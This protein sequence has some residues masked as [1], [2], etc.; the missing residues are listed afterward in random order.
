MTL[1]KTLLARVSLPSGVFSTVWNNITFQ[2]FTKQ[3]NGGP[4]ECVIAYA[5]PFDYDGA[6]L[7]EGNDVELIVSDS[8]TAAISTAFDNG[9]FNTRT[10]YRGYISLIERLSDGSA[11][12]VTVHILGY[13]TLLALDVLKNGSQTTLYSK[14]TDGMTTVSGDL[15]AADIGLLFRAV[16][17]RFIAETGSTRIFYGPDDIPNTGTSATYIFQQKTYRDAIDK[18]KSLAPTNVYWYVDETGRISFKAVSS[19]PTHRFIIG[20][21]FTSVDVQRSLETVRNSVL[22]W[23]GDAIY[24]HYEDAASIALYGRRT[25]CLN[26]YGI[27]DTNAADAAGAKFLAENKDAAVTLT[28]TI[29]DNN[30]DAGLGYDIESIQPGD[31]CAFLGFSSNLSDIF[32]D[33]MII[34]EVAYNL[35]SVQI[36]VELVKS[37]LVDQQTSQAQD[38]NDI[39]TGGLGIAE[40]YS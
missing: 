20:R 24:K 17:D 11:E 27:S 30:N 21:H 34:T 4:G 14:S 3:L 7:R 13:Y 2:G 19:A 35:D 37:G 1:P 9:S 16:V 22:I 40:S 12:T 26:D 36:K 32:R 8:D 5:V 28:C 29:I 25:E 38:I 31:T 23:N 15:G 18:L 39:A 10:I 6:D 33:N